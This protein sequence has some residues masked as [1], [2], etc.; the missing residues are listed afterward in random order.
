VNSLG[1]PARIRFI[2]SADDYGYSVYQPYRPYNY[3]RP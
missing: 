1:K 2:Q 3:S